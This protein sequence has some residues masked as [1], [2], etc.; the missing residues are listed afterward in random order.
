MEFV[1]NANWSD[2][3]S[4]LIGVILRLERYEEVQDNYCMV[5]KVKPNSPIAKALVK[6]GEYLIAV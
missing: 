6:E 1:P 4:D 2:N 5:T 3:K